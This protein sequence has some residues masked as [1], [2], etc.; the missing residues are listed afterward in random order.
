MKKV[1]FGSTLLLLLAC[2][3]SVV[4][5]ARVKATNTYYT[6]ADI[7]FASSSV[8]VDLY[9]TYQASIPNEELS[10]LVTWTSSDIEVA[11]ISN[12]GLITTR[13]VG[14]STIT[15]SY[16]KLSSSF[17]LNVFTS[18]SSPYIQLSDTN[19]TL[20]YGDT[21]RVDSSLIYKGEVVEDAVISWSVED[22]SVLDVKGNNKY[23][24]LYALTAGTTKVYASTTYNGV[25]VNQAIDVRVVD[26]IISIEFDEEYVKL[27]NGQYV[28][29]LDRD[30]Y[31]DTDPKIYINGVLSSETFTW[32]TEDSE[33]ATINSIGLIYGVNYGETTVTGNYQ[34]T[35]EVSIKVIVK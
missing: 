5:F 8:N 29:I 34:N 26:Q 13:S 28:A 25:H 18:Y 30:T 27:E 16:G 22:S 10:K 12:T 35:V 1:L 21:Y 6:K 15:A 19:I 4:T 7:A 9:S 2:S 23:A 20:A 24:T 31:L 32:S 33:I 17:T 14:K 11:S 3:T